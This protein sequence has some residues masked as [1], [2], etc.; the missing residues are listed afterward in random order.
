MKNLSLGGS[1]LLFFC[2]AA[3]S[4]GSSG[5]DVS[6]DPAY[7]EDATVVFAAGG[8]EPTWRGSPR[9]GGRLHIDYDFARLPQC[10]NQ[11]RVVSW[12]I[13]VSYRFDGGRATTAALDGSPGASSTLDGSAIEI[14]KDARSIELWFENRAV[15]GYDHC[16]AWDSRFG[17]NYV[18]DITPAAE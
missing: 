13:E 10:R 18:H 4:G 6:A 3:C 17:A 16:D 12:V 1:L 15:G 5:T 11:S 8:W 7:T 2:V 14:P 9:A